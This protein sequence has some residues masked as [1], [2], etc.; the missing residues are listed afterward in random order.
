MLTSESWVLGSNLS[1]VVQLASMMLAPRYTNKI[2]YRFDLCKKV[3]GLEC[4]EKEFV[5]AVQHLVD[6]NFVEIQELTESPK[7]TVQA[8]SKLLAKCSSEERENRGEREEIPPIPPTGGVSAKKREKQF[9]PTT[10][11]SLDITSWEQWLA[12]R[13]NRKPAIK[14]ASMQ[15]AAEELSA[16][17]AQQAVV[18][19]HSIANGYQ[20]LY[21][22]KTNGAAHQRAPPMRLRTADEIE[23]EERARGDWDAQH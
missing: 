4:T 15:A 22:P 16:F 6:T 17:G 5:T 2:P 8:A 12:Y 13:A 20:G 23:A 3:M 1:R 11:P 19:K 10:I 18:V 14:P 7:D 9:D 21:A